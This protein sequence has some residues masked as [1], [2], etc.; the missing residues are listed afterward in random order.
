MRLFDYLERKYVET[1]LQ[2]QVEFTLAKQ[3]EAQAAQKL[4][5]A[6]RSF[7][8]KCMY[9]K[10]VVHYVLVRLGLASA[11][12]AALKQVNDAKA[13]ATAAEAASAENVTQIK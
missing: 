4:I 9:I 12:E 11:P 10:L 13:A 1:N 8:R 3:A 5:D 7:Y 2:L 6:Q